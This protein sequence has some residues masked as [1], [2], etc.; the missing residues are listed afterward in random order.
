VANRHPTTDLVVFDNQSGGDRD[1]W[2]LGGTTHVISPPAAETAMGQRL[3]K[4]MGATL[5][6]PL[7]LSIAVATPAL[8]ANPVPPYSVPPQPV[9][10]SVN[11]SPQGNYPG[12]N[13]IFNIFV[14]NSEQPPNGNVT[15]FNE[16]LTAPALPPDQQTNTAIGIPIMLSPGQAILNT[17][18]LPIPSDFNQSSFTA[19][20][21]VFLFIGNG[22]SNPLKLTV[23]TP[24]VLLGLERSTTQ[25]TSSS[26]S[27][28]TQTTQTATQS[29]TVSTTLLAAGVALPSIVVVILLILL[30]RGRGV[31]K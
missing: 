29:G 1:A 9:W 19:N 26:T 14:V 10:V 12:G 16:T 15:L 30:V 21:V 2:R 27:Q 23:S 31:P 6:M 20:L 24:V 17:I 22:T 25:T 4:L 8:A 11:A 3:S 28:T 5:L 18:A 13:E 7:M